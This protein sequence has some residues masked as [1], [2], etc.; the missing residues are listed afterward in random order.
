[1]GS[2][3]TNAFNQDADQPHFPPTEQQLNAM[4]RLDNIEFIE[5][6]PDHTKVEVKIRPNLYDEIKIIEREEVPYRVDLN[7]EDKKTKFIFFLCN[8]RF[9]IERETTSSKEKIRTNRQNSRKCIKRKSEER[10]SKMV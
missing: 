1:M 4:E 2:R 10:Y 3:F 7:E 9:S 8:E 5:D 6:T